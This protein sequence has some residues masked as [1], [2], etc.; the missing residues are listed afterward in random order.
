MEGSSSRDTLVHMDNSA[1]EARLAAIKAKRASAEWQAGVEATK[2]QQAAEAAQPVL[3]GKAYE[4]QPGDTLLAVGGKNGRMIFK[5]YRID[6]TVTDAYRTPKARTRMH[7][8]LARHGTFILRA[9][10]PVRYKRKAN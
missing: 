3:S 4:L 8:E 10:Y 2:A 1:R 6:D 5:A 7:L 9:D